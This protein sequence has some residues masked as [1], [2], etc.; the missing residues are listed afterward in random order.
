MIWII[1]IAILSV[2]TI[3]SFSKRLNLKGW[4]RLFWIVV[5]LEIVLLADL[6]KDLYLLWEGNE[7]SKYLLPPYSGLGYFSFYAGTRFWA[8][9]LA[10]FVVGLI[11]F[12]S[13]KWLNKR[14]MGKFF[15]D[16]EFYFLWLG[17]FLSGHP[18]WIVYFIALFTIMLFLT[19]YRK[20]RTSFYYLWFPAGIATILVNQWLSIN[21]HSYSSLFI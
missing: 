3:F 17:S 21:W 10:G 12:L 6:T 19:V 15:Y 18:G 20:S 4:R 13:F 2:L 11:G 16:E 9:Y 8:P 5:L 7:L 14:G 1:N